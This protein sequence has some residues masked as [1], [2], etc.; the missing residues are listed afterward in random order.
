MREERFIV[1]VVEMHYIQGLSQVEIAKKLG[2]SRTTISRT[3][4]QARQRGY[5]EFKVNYPDDIEPG[6]EKLLEEKYGLKEAVIV[7]E[8]SDGD[9]GKEIASYAA[10]YILRVLKKK[11]SIAFSNGH[12]LYGI[13]DCMKEDVRLKF[14][15]T[16]GIEVLPLFAEYNMPP[17][18]DEKDRIAY[19]NQNVEMIAELFHG[20]SY[21]FMVP[22]IVSSEKIR[23]EL[24]EEP[25]IREIM[26]KIQNV[27][28]AVTGIGT[29][30]KD[31]FGA[32]VGIADESEYDRLRAKGG[33]GEFLLH[34]IDADGKVIDDSYE[35]RLTCIRLEDFK[36]IPIRIGVAYGMRKKEAIRAVLREK[37]VN[38]LITDEHVAE[39]LI[40]N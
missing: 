18:T 24:L 7:C 34:I 31:S 11:M 27:D 33:I 9:M 32:N 37:L 3:V 21:H 22:P 1:K 10:D 36:K 12:T 19:S 29:L 13:A 8:K 15:N 4:A 17:D 26:T 40:E 28:M 39:Y 20:H 5:I 38:V 23:R 30:D 16:K 14:L 2:V 6:E 25:C 35:G